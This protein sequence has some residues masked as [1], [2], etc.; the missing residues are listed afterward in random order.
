MT[1]PPRPARG[2]TRVAISGTFNGT[3]WANV[4][5]CL[6]TPS[7]AL[8]QGIA[9]NVTIGFF[10]AYVQAWCPQLN[11]KL[12][13]LEAS[14]VMFGDSGQ[15]FESS[16]TSPTNG[17]DS[18]VEL[19]GSVALCVSWRVSTYYRGGHPRTY[20][21]G[22]SQDRLGNAKSWSEQTVADFSAAAGYFYNY[23][24][25]ISVIG[26][27]SVSLGYLQQFANGGSLKKPREY[28]NPPVFHPFVGW[29]IHPRVDSQ[30]RRLGR[31]L[32]S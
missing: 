19:P 16:T 21:A 28:L 18:G 24:H 30:R 27:S 26:V 31:E 20:L 23:V 2:V 7:G 8:T 4:F 25:N 29:S 6:V 5:H 11:Q 1:T 14:S 15:V 9:D 12:A 13:V 10:N 22:I 3:N 17:Q 32:A